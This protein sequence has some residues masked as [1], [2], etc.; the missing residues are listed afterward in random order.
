MSPPIDRFFALDVHKHYLVAGARNAQQEV[1]LRPRRV[2]LTRFPT[3]AAK[4]F[5]PTDAV[6]IEATTNAWYVYDLVQPLVGRAIVTHPYH[7]KLIAASLVKTD[8]IDTLTLTKLLAANI[9]PEVWVPPHPVRELRALIAHRRRLVGQRSA[10][11]NR[12]HSLLHRHSIIPP[13]GDPFSQANRDWWTNL[14]LSPTQTL[15]ARHDLALVDYLSGL[16][17]EVEFELARLSVSEPW[18]KMVPLL[19]QLPGFGLLTVM[20][21]LGAIGDITRFPSDKKLVG[22]AGLGSRVHDSG[23]T[24]R[25]GGITKQGRRDLRAALVEAA[26]AAVR[27]STYWQFQFDKLA[28]RIGKEKAI[29]AIARKLLVTVWHVLT[30]READRHADVDQVAFKLMI[31]SWKLDDDLRRGLTTR[32]FV[33]YHLMCLDLGH[34]LE[35]IQRGGYNRPIASLEEL[36]TLRPELGPSS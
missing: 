29:V 14:S 10:A 28:V 15:R 19:I 7:V 3:W 13:Q 11:K 1:V 23:K 4:T 17:L 26:W 9:I 12:L 5:R 8:K 6:V 33:R 22:Y 32:Q 24:H 20:T 16:V 35:S 36:L 31:W 34:D 27:S 2:S 18:T 30:K 21:V 25:R